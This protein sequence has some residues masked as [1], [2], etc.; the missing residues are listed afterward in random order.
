MLLAQQIEQMRNHFDI[1][2]RRTTETG[3]SDLAVEILEELGV[4]LEEMQVADDELQWQNERLA[5]ALRL[6]EAERRRYQEL[7]D[8]APDGYIVTDM[9]GTIREANVAAA[10][11]LHTSAAFLTGK[12]LVVFIAVQ[13]RHLFRNSI[14]RL[15]G[16]RQLVELGLHL[17]PRSGLPVA[18][19]ARIVT[20]HDGAKHGSGLR[21]LLRDVTHR[22]LAEDH[23]RRLNAELEN[24]VQE[25]TAHLVEATRAKDDLLVQERAARRSAERARNRLLLLSQASERL[26]SSLDY[27]TTL[28]SVAD[29]L[30]DNLADNAAIFLVG[31]DERIDMV[32]SAQAR[33]VEGDGRRQHTEFGTDEFR[34]IVA[35]VVRTGSPSVENIAG[36]GAPGRQVA[37]GDVPWRSRLVVPLP[38][39]GRVVGAL[40][41]EARETRKQYNADDLE[42]AQELARRA[43]Q[44]IGSAR[45]FQ[46]VRREIEERMQSNAALRATN[47]AL[48]AL[49]QASPLAVIQVDM[50][51]TVKLWSPAAEKIFGWSERDVLGRRLPIFMP[52]MGGL[53]PMMEHDSVVQAGIP[54]LEVQCV[55]NDGSAIDVGLWTSPLY[56]REGDVAGALGI[57]ADFSERKRTNNELQRAKEEAE[58]ASRTKDHFLAVLSHEL[59]TPLTAV[60][61]AVQVLHEDRALPADARSLVDLIGRNMELETR[62][63]DDL[64]DIT[65]IVRGKLEL[66]RDVI[67]AHLL[68]ENVAD[69]YQGELH[70]KKLDLHLDLAADRHVVNADAARLQ[71]V[72]GNLIQN[73]CKFTPEGGHVMVWTENVGRGMLR[74]GITDTGIGIDPELLPRIFDAFEQGEQTIT[75]R[76]GGLGLGLAISRSLIDMHGG[77]LNVA[78]DGHNQGATFTVE[79]Q[80]VGGAPAEREPETMPEEPG[81]EMVRGR[82]LLVD[83]HE[84][85]SR[86]LKLLLEKRGYRTIV[87]GTVRRALDLAATEEFDVLISDIC[88]PDGSG[89]DL[90]NA[91]RERGEVKGIALSGFGMEEDIRRSRAAG[92]REHLIKPVSIRRLEEA[93]VQLL[94]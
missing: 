92:F 89:L 83:D 52:D 77:H 38:V 20:V 87:A 80:T 27:E 71:Q 70:R 91:L 59:R 5:R 86:V 19:E 10:T 33:D 17:R 34:A 3:M 28:S 46:Q 50:E 57:I 11:M 2:S 1:L 68:L 45:L 94:K 66:H 93:I 23:V 7:F 22:K 85:T 14:S 73:A 48:Q 35:D 78:S 21:W 43:V 56:T 41:V 12:P 63:I 49:I 53:F 76:F 32:A 4:A 25:R 18:V 9:N 84:D 60:M 72:L 81:A 51:G 69:T 24:R 47:R 67:D 13:D 8:M 26:A 39:Q 29:L 55:R 88:L 16:P 79:L 30:V 44:A 40:V 6:A 61:T 42:L 82:V 62:L 64:L 90:M 31:E 74:I 37:A 15:G 65:R 36:A 58:Q 75:R 54:G